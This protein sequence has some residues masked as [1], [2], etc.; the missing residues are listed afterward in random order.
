MFSSLASPQTIIKIIRNL[1]QKFLWHGHKPGK[2]WAL[3]S[4]DKI[5]KPTSLGGLGLCDLGKINNVMGEKIW[6]H[7]LKYPEELWA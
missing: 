1:Q 4:W 3:F 2:N 6:W 5:C 7:W